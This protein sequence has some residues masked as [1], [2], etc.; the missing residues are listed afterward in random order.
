MLLLLQLE[1]GLGGHG[2]VR[3]KGG[4]EQLGLDQSRLLLQLLLQ[5]SLNLGLGLGQCLC[6]LLLLLL[7]LLLPGCNHVC[8]LLPVG[9]LGLCRGCSVGTDGV[10]QGWYSYTFSGHLTQ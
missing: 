3:Q 6:L 4:V 1:Q 5:V 9:F 2:E 7:L 8:Q 10:P